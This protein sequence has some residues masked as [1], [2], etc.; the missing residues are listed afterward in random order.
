MYLLSLPPPV[1]KGVA[2]VSSEKSEVGKNKEVIDRNEFLITQIGNY[3]LIVID[4][5]DSKRLRL[6]VLQC[7][8]LYHLV[9]ISNFRNLT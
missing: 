4:K 9:G 2:I 5:N 8:T 1:T 7:P 3:K 6:I